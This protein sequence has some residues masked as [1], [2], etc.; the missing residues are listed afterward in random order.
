MLFF[1]AFVSENDDDENSSKKRNYSV[2]LFLT[3]E[4]CQS[5]MMEGNATKLFRKMKESP[6]KTVAIK[7]TNLGL[8]CL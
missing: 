2:R 6:N 3:K 7:L 5:Q 1:F 4:I 8:L